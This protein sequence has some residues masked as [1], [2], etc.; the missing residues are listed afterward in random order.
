MGLALF[1]L[2]KSHPY[3]V[4]IFGFERMRVERG[5]VSIKLSKVSIKNGRTPISIQKVLIKM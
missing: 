3:G 1:A 2:A 4:L 5:R